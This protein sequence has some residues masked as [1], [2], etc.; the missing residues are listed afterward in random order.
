MNNKELKE[1][2]FLSALIQTYVEYYVSYGTLDKDRLMYVLCS[3]TEMKYQKTIQKIE[4]IKNEIF[5]KGFDWLSVEYLEELRYKGIS[6]PENENWEDIFVDAFIDE[7]IQIFDITEKLNSLTVTD[8]ILDNVEKILSIN[9]KNELTV[10]DQ[11]VEKKRSIEDENVITEIHQTY[12]NVDQIIS[13]ENDLLGAISDDISQ[14][15]KTGDWDIDFDYYE[16]YR[17]DIPG[18]DIFFR[19][20]E[21][22]VLLYRLEMFESFLTENPNQTQKLNKSHYNQTFKK[23]LNG[24]DQFKTSLMKFLIE[25]YSGLKGKDIAIMISALEKNKLIASFQNKQLYN[26]LRFDF[27]DIGTNSGINKYL[28]TTMR[29]D[30]EQKRNVELHAEKIKKQIENFPK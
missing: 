28:T 5:N 30:N 3:N 20:C 24:T 25:N 9:D 27:G 17:N 16:E 21:L 10:T 22:L 6:K 15:N 23:Y 14:F 1:S 29:N 19:L 4:E 2:G 13:Y 8:E 18:V 26:S 11:A 12:D 7:K